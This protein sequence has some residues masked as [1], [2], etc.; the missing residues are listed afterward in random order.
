MATTKTQQVDEVFSVQLQEGALGQ[1]LVCMPFQ[2]AV[3]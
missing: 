3:L 2:L 1:M